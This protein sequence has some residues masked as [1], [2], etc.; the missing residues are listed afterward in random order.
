MAMPCFNTYPSPTGLANIGKSSSAI[1]NNLKYVRSNGKEN[2]ALEDSHEVFK[3]FSNAYE[4]SMTA[5]YKS[6]QVTE[7]LTAISFQK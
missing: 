5:S 2:I 3:E 1:F 4:R 7:I 6:K